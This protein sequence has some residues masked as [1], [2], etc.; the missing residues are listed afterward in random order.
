[1]NGA[2]EDG[3]VLATGEGSESTGKQRPT[4]A[5][6]SAAPLESKT[7]ASRARN[8]AKGSGSDLGTHR[9]SLYRCLGGPGEH[10]CYAYVQHP[11]TAV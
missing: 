11:Q 2:S 7:L 9:E 5:A 10:L 4:A 8:R 3:G 6:S 1:M